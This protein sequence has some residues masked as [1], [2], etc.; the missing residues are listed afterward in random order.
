MPAYLKELVD[1]SNLRKSPRLKTIEVPR[2]NRDVLRN[3]FL[4]Q[5][6][7]QWNNLDLKLRRA[8]SLNIFK[9]LFL[10]SKGY[11][12]KP[13]ISTISPR[14]NEILLNSFRLDF[15]N[16]NDDL[17]RH[18]FP[19]PPFCPKCPTQTRETHKHFFL[20][21]STY[22]AARN[23]LFLSINSLLKPGCT[24]QKLNQDKIISLLLYAN[25]NKILVY[26]NQKAV[27]NATRNRSTSVIGF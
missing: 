18:N 5:T 16:L 2:T 8:P 21:C 19:V 24:I 25:N 11:S 12:N 22:T 14:E 26:E 15:T 20:K 10:V 7:L 4:V 3:S 9:R 13:M 1:Q 6:A 17:N 27:L 23:K